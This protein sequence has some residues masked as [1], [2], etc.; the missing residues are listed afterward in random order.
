M[1][2]E[3]TGVS[4][5]PVVANVKLSHLHLTDE[6]TAARLGVVERY[7]R[8]I[9]NG[10]REPGA[11]LL[12]K[13]TEVIHGIRASQIPLVWTSAAKLA[14]FSFTKASVEELSYVEEQIDG[15]LEIDEKDP[16]LHHLK[17][18]IIFARQ[19][20]GHQARVSH[21]LAHKHWTRAAELAGDNKIAEAV[22]RNSALSMRY[23]IERNFEAKLSS[24]DAYLPY[25][26]QYRA[27][28]QNM[29][30]LTAWFDTLEMSGQSGDPSLIDEDLDGFLKA[31]E[32]FGANG[33]RPAAVRAV[34]TKL[35]TMDAPA[36]Q[37][38]MKRPKFLEWYSQFEIEVKA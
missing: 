2:N 1:K 21:E 30:W 34:V 25:R 17:A 24:P 18:A 10:R 36:P 15:L 19:P 9:Q 11:K 32:G 12:A 23:F 16:G 4:L 28:A 37:A 5:H 31:Y 7:W 3:N 8:D 20:E 14:R 33:H 26:E 29:N 27:F 35:K 13:A 22:F 6:K 38:V